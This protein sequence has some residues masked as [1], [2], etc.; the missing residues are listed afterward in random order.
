MHWPRPT[1]YRKRPEITLKIL[2]VIERKKKTVKTQIIQGANLNTSQ[3]N[4]Y[5]NQLLDSGAIEMKKE[6][7]PKR[8]YFILTPDGKI[9]MEKLRRTKE[10]RLRSRPL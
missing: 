8:T 10:T 3:A 9:F 2:S 5:L 7:H 1:R 6:T 4:R